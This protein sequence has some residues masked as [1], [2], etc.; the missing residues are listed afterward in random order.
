MSTGRVVVVG[1]GIAGA[2]AA[3]TL[4]ERG[5]SV[6]VLEAGPGPGQGGSGNP[7]AILYPKL[8]GP[9]LTPTHLQS[10]AWLRALDILRD[11]RLTAQMAPTGVLWLDSPRQGHEAIGEDHPWWQRKVWRVDATQA[12]RLAG[13]ELT[14]PALWLPEAG[15]LQ[16]PGL[17]AALLSHPNIR[18]QADTTLLAAA[19]A[20]SSKGWLLDTSQGRLDTPALVLACAGGARQLGLSADLPLQPVRG[21]ISS[22]PACLPLQTTLCFGGYLT[23]ALQG[24]HCLGAT[25][26]PGRS[27]CATDEQDRESNR[28][29]LAALLPDVAAALP[30][31]G[32]WQDRASLRWQTPDYLPL[33]GRLPWL[34]GLKQVLAGIAPGKPVPSTAGSSP[35]L[36]V[37]LGHGSKGYTQAWLAAELIADQLEGRT[38]VL[39]A[40]LVKRL[41][42][43][44]FL[45]RDWRRGLLRAAAATR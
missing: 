7:V 39:P 43:E 29:T 10:L 30:A 24:R 45:W 35:P 21:Q 4:A 31:C 34:P 37:S 36:M 13:I 1:A 42:P 14:M 27:D 9:A 11:E 33:A 12:S 40:E 16:A 32:Q 20:D 8:V 25:F 6:T 3:W 38:P 22:L 23:P 28:A 26:Q 17:L 44:R 2:T 5:W 18:L 15:V 19:P 41:L